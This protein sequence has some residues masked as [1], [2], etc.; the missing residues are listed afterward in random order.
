MEKYEQFKPDEETIES[1]Q[2]GFEARLLCHNIQACEKKRNWCQALVGEA[3]RSIIKKL[4]QRATWA[5]VKQELCAVL[6][7]PDPK[8][9]AIEG[10]LQYQAKGKGLGE[11][12]ADII[13]KAATDDADMQAKL[14]LKAFLKAVPEG[15]GRELRRK[16]FQSVREALNPSVPVLIYSG[17]S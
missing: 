7:D 11:M 2:D 9:R 13:T 1:W 15:L 8:D 12:A 5:Q 17:M 14:W 3:V 6:G 16:H 10:L 4:P